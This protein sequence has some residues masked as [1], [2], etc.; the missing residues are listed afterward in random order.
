MSTVR[1]S[2]DE[3]RDA[4]ARIFVASG[5]PA[6][7]AA[8]VAD[9]LVRADLWGHQSHGVLRVGWYVDRIRSGVMNAVTK[10][11]LVVDGGAIA[12][13]DGHDGVGQVV[14]ARAAQE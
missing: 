8:L 6:E 9:S 14:T 2:A 5:V 1:V 4:A 13:L 12:T 11:E 10:A 3:L 7:D